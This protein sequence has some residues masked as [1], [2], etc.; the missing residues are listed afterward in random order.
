M[1]W[2]E[3]QSIENSYR[4]KY[5]QPIVELIGQTDA[6]AQEKIHGSNLSFFVTKDDLRVAKRTSLLSNEE[7]SSFFRSDII[8]DRYKLQL[9][10]LF[11]HLFAHSGVSS[12]IVYGE[13][14]GGIY[15][16][17]EVIKTNNHSKVQSG[18]YYSPDIKWLAFDIKLN[19]EEKSQWMDFHE[20]CKICAHYDIPMIPAVKTGKLIDMI[21]LDPNYE[22]LVYQLYNLPKIEN[23]ISEGYVI[24]PV[25]TYID[26]YG[27]RF[28]VKL[29]SSS[30]SE[31]KEKKEFVPVIYEG[32]VK[33]IVEGID[34]HITDERLRSAISKVGTVTEKDFGKLLGLLN[35]DILAELSKDFEEFTTLSKEDSKII[36][37]EVNNHSA[38]FIRKNFLN[39]IDGVY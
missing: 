10:S 28:I 13:I 8:L 3:Y 39:I 15:P 35:K 38:S 1:K 21:N 37:K 34:V 22:S 30:F 11:D 25:N 24:R 18:V 16:H 31:R 26:H 7:T 6:V 14:F 27:Q 32:I 36:S 2:N 12:I 23:N 20:M 17:P 5:V 33:T 29:K 4:T 19:Y 9:R